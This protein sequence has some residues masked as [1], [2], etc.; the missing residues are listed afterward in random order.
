[1]TRTV[2]NI[3]NTL[4]G[5]LIG[6]FFLYITLKG[7]SMDEII[8]SLSEIKTS[9]AIGSAVS[10]IAVYFF[11]GLRWGVILKNSGFELKKRDLVNSVIIGYFINSFTPKLGE[12]FRCTMIHRISGIKVSKLLGTVVTERVWDLI[13]LALG[14][15]VLFV[16]EYK[17]VFRL[18][19]FG[20]MISGISV[21]TLIFSAL[22]IAGLLLLVILFRIFRKKYGKMSLFTKVWNFVLE[23][24]ST[25]VLTFKIKKFGLFMFLTGMIW[26]SLIMMNY[27]FLKSLNET[28]GFDFY[29]AIVVLFIGAI[30][31][32]LPSPGGIGTTHYFI[33]QL[34]LAF[35]LSESAGI[36][37]GILSNGLTFIFTILLGIVALIYNEIRIYHQKKSESHLVNDQKMA[38]VP[39]SE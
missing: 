15:M 19:D 4:L 23:I 39:L 34:F 27:C 6:G 32:A 28:E 10:L 21:S 25:M 12:L 3:L 29:F 16:T 18:F 36:N 31:W 38:N 35:R 9:W 1:M 8:R 20:E 24:W 26:V 5:F 22:G 14:L 17:R 11:R 7:K 13:I 30:G 2:K 37:F 33:L